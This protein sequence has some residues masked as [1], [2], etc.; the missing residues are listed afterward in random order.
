[1]AVHVELNQR[2]SLAV[3][4]SIPGDAALAF[5]GVQEDQFC[6]G[7]VAQLLAYEVSDA[8]LAERRMHEF[9]QIAPVQ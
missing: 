9:L 6:A 8:K 1:M 5:V 2:S 4:L 3:G 7:F